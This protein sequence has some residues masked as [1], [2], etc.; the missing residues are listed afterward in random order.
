MIVLALGALAHIFL[1]FKSTLE[2]L[3]RRANMLLRSPGF[4]Y[5]MF[6]FFQYIIVSFLDPVVMV[7]CS[8]EIVSQRVGGIR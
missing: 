5:Y 8:W 3:M 2:G 7:R 6:R 4:E 1:G